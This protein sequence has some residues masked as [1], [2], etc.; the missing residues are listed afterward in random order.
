MVKMYEEKKKNRETYLKVKGRVTT[1][2]MTVGGCK[3]R[4]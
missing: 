1:S 4:F 2:R 3:H